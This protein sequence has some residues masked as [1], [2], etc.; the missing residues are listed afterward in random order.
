MRQEFDYQLLKKRT[1]YLALFLLV[2]LFMKLIGAPCL[3]R[4]LFKVP[5]PTCGSTRAIIA[6]LKLNLKGYLYYNAMSLFV[7]LS[8]VIIIYKEFLPKKSEFLAYFFLA[9]NLV[10]YFYRLLANTI[11]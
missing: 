10:Y 1:G 5:C 11:P 3:I 2:A 9:I 6:L 8:A 7:F 4:Q